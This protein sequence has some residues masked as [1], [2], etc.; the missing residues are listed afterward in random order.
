MQKFTRILF[1][2]KLIFEQKKIEK[3]IKKIIINDLSCTKKLKWQ[4]QKFMISDWNSDFIFEFSAKNWI[5]ITMFKDGGVFSK[6]NKKKTAKFAKSCI[7]AM[8]FDNYYQKVRL[9]LMKSFA[10]TKKI[11]CWMYLFGGSIPN[12]KNRLKWVFCSVFGDI[13]A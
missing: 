7:A 3:L 5:R 12:P 6:F 2:S 9:K 4:L 8:I 13:Q 11:C 10:T 1:C